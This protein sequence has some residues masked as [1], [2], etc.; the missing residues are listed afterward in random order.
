MKRNIA[1]KIKFITKSEEYAEAFVHERWNRVLNA[2]SH[3]EFY[4]ERERMTDTD[5]AN[6]GG[7]ISYLESEWLP[8]KT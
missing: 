7:L 2:L 6:I 4:K 8:Y 5:W 1:A 3:E